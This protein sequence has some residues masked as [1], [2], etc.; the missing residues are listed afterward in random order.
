[1]KAQIKTYEYKARLAGTKQE[2]HTLK[3]ILDGKVVG[4]HTSK[5]SNYIN[6]L[7]IDWK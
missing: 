7:K 5:S 4:I 3:L 6:R 2:Y 1:M